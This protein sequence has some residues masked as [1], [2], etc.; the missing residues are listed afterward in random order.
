M[1]REFTRVFG[2]GPE[3]ALGRK[4]DELVVPDDQRSG[5]EEYQSHRRSPKGRFRDGATFD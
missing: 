1:N 3:E 2:Y 4:L 5:L